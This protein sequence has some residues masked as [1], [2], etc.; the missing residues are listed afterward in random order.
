MSRALAD[1]PAR[2]GWTTLLSVFMAVAMRSV[3]W[4]GEPAVT[5]PERVAQGKTFTILVGDGARTGTVRFLD[6]DVPLHRHGEGLRAILGVP[7]DAKPGEHGYVLVLQGE[8]GRRRVEGKLTVV[9]GK[10][11]TDVITLPPKSRDPKLLEIMRQ[12]NRV[13]QEV[14]DRRSDTQ[15]WSGI[16]KRP[17]PGRMTSPYGNRRVYKGLRQ[18]THRGVDLA[19]A[20]GWPVKAP[21]AG[22]V[23]LARMFT[24]LGGTVVVDHGLGIFSVYMHLSEFV[25]AEGA[26]V[27]TGEVIAK[28][29][30]T[31]MVTGPHLHWGMVVND[32]RVDPMEW[33]ARLV[34]D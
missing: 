18:G 26:R 30:Q 7:L 22:T 11:R 27:A 20:E 1:S 3:A 28:V 31:G 2:P 14:L 5:A 16:F 15:G 4:A 23:V 12:E 10:Y 25:A 24:A 34:A 8:A 29:G 9:D 17:V 13:V 6:R 32:V 19:G 21:A 33:T